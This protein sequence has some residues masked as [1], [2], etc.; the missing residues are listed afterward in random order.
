MQIILY[1]VWI[2]IRA[3]EFLMLL[4]ALLSWFPTPAGIIDILYTLTEPIITPMRLLFDRLDINPPIPFDLP[5]LFTFICISLL[6]SLL[7]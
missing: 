4:R 7:F 5:F 3:A 6:E 1:A 2:V